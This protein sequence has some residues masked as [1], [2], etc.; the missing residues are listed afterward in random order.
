M[1][2]LTIASQKGGAGKTTLAAHHRYYLHGQEPWEY[3][4]AA[5]VTLCERCHQRETQERREAERQ[6]LLAMRMAELYA[7][8]V[9]EIAAEPAQ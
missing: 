7:S 5:F 1:C 3:P 4:Q 8:N 6:W 2:I 9:R